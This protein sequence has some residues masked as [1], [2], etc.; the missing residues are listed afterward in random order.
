MSLEIE[1]DGLHLVL[2]IIAFKKLAQNLEHTLKRNVPYVHLFSRKP[3]FYIKIS[4]LDHVICEQVFAN[5]HNS[6]YLLTILHTR[7]GC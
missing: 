1:T 5:R 3:S 6:R 2:T 7:I 4:D